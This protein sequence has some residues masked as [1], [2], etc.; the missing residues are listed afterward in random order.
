MRLLYLYLK[1]RIS[2]QKC[3]LQNTPKGLSTSF[4]KDSSFHGNKSRPLINVASFKEEDGQK[5]FVHS[6]KH[7]SFK[8]INKSQRLF[9]IVSSSYKSFKFQ[10]S[11]QIK[12]FIYRALLLKSLTNS[13]SNKC[14]LKTQTLNQPQTFELKG[15]YRQCQTQNM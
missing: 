8:I 5:L 6:D 4:N 3:Q 10:E 15:I 1:Q 14:S 11:W 7:L 2:L 9:F 13:Q 12:P